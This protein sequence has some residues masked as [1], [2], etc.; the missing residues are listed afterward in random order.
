MSIFQSVWRE[1][2]KEELKAFA[3]TAATA[4]ASKSIEYTYETHFKKKDESLSVSDK[5]QEKSKKKK[6]KK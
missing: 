6:H 3:V 1:I 4:I 2:C 5:I